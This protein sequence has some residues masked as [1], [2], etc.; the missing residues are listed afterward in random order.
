M[1]EAEQ[2]CDRVGIMQNGQLR[3]IGSIAHLRAK[4]AS[5]FELSVNVHNVSLRAAAKQLVAAQWPNVSIIEE[6]AT[7]IKFNLP[8]QQQ[9]QQQQQA[10]IVSI[11]SIFRFMEQHKQQYFAAYTGW[12]IVARAGVGAPR[13]REQ[14]G[15][16]AVAKA[17]AAAAASNSSN[18]SS[19]SS[20]LPLPPATARCSN[21]TP[22]P[23]LAMAPRSSCKEASRVSL[24]QLAVNKQQLFNNKLLV[25]RL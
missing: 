6:H 16:V 15:G 10:H 5:G 8:K 20:S 7:S 17:A 23:R 21:Q 18:S 1:E 13:R 2:L 11:A 9:Q 22:Q 25:Y 4:F 3:C 24:A 19:S 12:C 14:A